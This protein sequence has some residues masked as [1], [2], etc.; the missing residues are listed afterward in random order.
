MEDNFDASLA[1]V[2]Q[3]EGGFVNNKADPGGATNMGIT[4]KTLAAWRHV[5]PWSSLPVSAVKQLTKDEASQIY[6]ANYWRPVHGDDLPKGL[7]YA[8]FDFGVNSGPVS[9]I[10]ALQAAVGVPGDGLIGPVTLAAAA[11]MPTT[12]ILVLCNNRLDALRHLPT[13]QTFGA[14][15]TNRV[16]AVRAA[17]LRMAS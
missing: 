6:K 3:S 10:K 15:W 9:A 14:G 17:A 2:L 13:W 11:R 4:R 7:D 8:V 1:L 5:S 12:A 16:A